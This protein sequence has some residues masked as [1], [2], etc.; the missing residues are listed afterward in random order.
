[1]EL[2]P[3]LL[4]RLVLK[5]RAIACKDVRPMPKKPIRR[6]ACALARHAFHFPTPAPLRTTHHSRLTTDD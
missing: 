2:G 4:E 1:M 6:I 3:N 5:A